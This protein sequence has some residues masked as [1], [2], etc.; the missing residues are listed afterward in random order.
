VFQSIKLRPTHAVVGWFV[1]KY[2]VVQVARR[3]RLPFGYSYK[4]SYAIPG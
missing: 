1:P 4:A 2:N 3:P